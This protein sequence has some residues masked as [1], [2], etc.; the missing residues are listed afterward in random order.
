MQTVKF[1]VTIAAGA[2]ATVI[3]NEVME[4]RL[5]R[6]CWEIVIETILHRACDHFDANYRSAV[7]AQEVPDDSEPMLRRKVPI[8]QHANGAAYLNSLAFRR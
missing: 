4:H 2:I 7:A 1:S 8:F 3:R 6:G 5:G